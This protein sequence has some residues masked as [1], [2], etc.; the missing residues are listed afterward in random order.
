M[1]A[2]NTS[3]SMFDS[4]EPRCEISVKNTFLT[5]TESNL[6]AR[7]RSSSLPSSVRLGSPMGSGK[8][9]R[10]D[11]WADAS[12]ASEH[13]EFDRQES[14]TS[15][16]S[17]ETASSCAASPAETTRTPLRASAR[18][19]TPGALASRPHIGGMNIPGRS[20]IPVVG[21]ASPASAAYALGRPGGP[22]GADPVAVAQALFLQ[23]LTMVIGAA[24]SALAAAGFVYNVVASNG[25]AGWCISARMQKTDVPKRRG[26][27][28]TLVKQALLKAAE[29]S[30][31]IFVSG[32]EAEPFQNTPLGFAVE[33]VMAPRPSEACWNVLKQGFCS[34]GCQC[35]WKHPVQQTT[36]NVLIQVDH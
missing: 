15:S 12:T 9:P 14:D 19:W 31:N 24:C 5:V 6:M 2:L 17:A 35:K 1:A 20:H 26:H 28:L 8:E 33:V 36:L 29:A 16:Q 23:Q 27:A 25:P 21:P 13:G 30:D 32:Y 10:I 11:V 4:D 22:G 3:M 34:R 7:K 18:A